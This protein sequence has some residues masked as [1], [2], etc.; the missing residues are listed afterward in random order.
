[1]TRLLVATAHPDDEVLIA[2]GTLAACAARGIATGVVC[3]TRGEEG[4]I[5]DPA[6]ATRETLPQVRLEELRAACAE[7]GVGWLKC[8]RRQDSCLRW[9]DRSGIVR[10]LTRVVDELRPNAVIT[11][12]PEGLYY[13]PDHIAAYDFTVAA[14]KRAADRPELYRSV[15]PGESM[16]EL[17][18]ALA[19]RGLPADLWGIEPAQFGAE[20]E[21]REDEVAVDVAPHVARK[22]AALRCHRTQVGPGHAFSA[23]PDDLA[24]R[25]LGIER[26][27][28]VDGAGADGW[29][30]RALGVAGVN[31]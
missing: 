27:V 20:P 11:F 15:W 29:L 21:D 30:A 17:V 8:Y 10:Q 12:G 1:M 25:F 7:L 9:S 24:Q 22:L 13:H 2:G 19:R 28:R 14:V 18:S 31:V 4:P 23:L 3:L 26:F 6:L 16:E 5:A